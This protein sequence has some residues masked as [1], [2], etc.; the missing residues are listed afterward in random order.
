MIITKHN[1]IRYNKMKAKL[2]YHG[3]T[4]KL[5]RRKRVQKQ[6]QES[7]PTHSHRQEGPL[8][9]TARTRVRGIWEVV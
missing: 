7:E 9:K 8:E 2:S 6:E 5:N 4:W 1:N 3:L